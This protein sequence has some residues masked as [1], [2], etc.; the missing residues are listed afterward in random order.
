MARTKVLFEPRIAA[1]NLGDRV[2]LLGYRN[3]LAVYHASDALLVP[4]LR[5][6]FCFAAVEAISAGIP[7]LRTQTGGTMAQII[8]DVTGRSTP[9]DREEFI[10]AAISFLADREGLRRMG[11]AAAAHA[12]TNLG[13]DLQVERTVTLYH[14]LALGERAD[15]VGWVYSPTSRRCRSV[16]FAPSPGTPNILHRRSKYFVSRSHEKLGPS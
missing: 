12:R 8:E 14:R 10:A 9:I 5:E 2:T 4:S 16:A 11:S 6:G 7:V 3:P 15:N 1:E 13:F